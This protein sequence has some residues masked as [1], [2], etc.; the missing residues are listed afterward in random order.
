MAGRCSL[1]GSRLNNGKC[2]FCGLDNR[3][4]DR[5]YLKDP[6]H[7]AEIAREADTPKA[8]PG[9]TQRPAAASAR[10]GSSAQKTVFTA[11][12]PAR[13]GADFSSRRQKQDVS[14]WQKRQNSGASRSRA[15]IVI[16]ILV[17]LIC[18]AGPVLFQIGKSVIETGTVPDTDSW[19][20]AVDSLFSDDDSS[21]DLNDYDAYDYVTREIPEDGT[22]YEVTLSDGFYQVGIHIPEGVYHVELAEESADLHIADTENIIYDSVWFGDETEYDEVTEADDIRLYNGAEISI[23]GG[24]SLLFTTDN[25]QPFTQETAANPLTESFIL[26]EGSSTAGEYIP[27]GMY[28]ILLAET[29][30]Y[31]SFGLEISYP[32]ELS[33]YLWASNSSGE[34]EERIRNV[35]IPAGTELTLDGGPVKL[36][37]SE[38]YFE[39]DL[40]DYPWN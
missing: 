35:I 9:Q 24:G 36:E 3:M 17:I 30:E 40:S 25:A 16:V 15:V 21:L 23:T 37:P 7:L 11:K 26:E 22:D 18:I 20:S 6:Y 38:G 13:K 10:S 28:D 8:P 31:I 34:P 19:Q 39:A 12:P 2:E 27:E 5:N 14:S 33:E 29:D 1:C 32:N 4:Y